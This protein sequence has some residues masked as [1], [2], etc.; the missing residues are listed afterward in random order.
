VDAA[1]HGAAKTRPVPLTR[2]HLLEDYG[3]LML[4]DRDTHAA[5]TRGCRRSSHDGQPTVLYC[6]P[7][8][9]GP[10][11]FHAWPVRRCRWRPFLNPLSDCS[12]LRSYPPSPSPRTLTQSRDPKFLG[13]EMSFSDNRKAFPSNM[14]RP[15]RMRGL[16]LVDNWRSRPRE[17]F[18]GLPECQRGA[19]QKEVSCAGLRRPAR[20]A[21]AALGGVG[22][23]GLAPPGRPAVSCMRTS[24]WSCTHVV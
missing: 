2:Y 22:R 18:A 11:S 14:Q 21:R 1:S 15:C 9:P 8:N 13:P 16:Q 4:L 5:H 19:G 12:L 23:M 24:A 10:R 3:L 7:T 6:V 17:P 20:A